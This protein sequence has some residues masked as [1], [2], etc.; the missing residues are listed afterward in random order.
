MKPQA[1]EEVTGAAL[2]DLLGYHL[3]RASIRDLAGF[4][5]ALGD[6]IKSIPFAVLCMIDEAPGITAA[7]IC[8][9]AG[10]QRANIAPM[11]AEFDARGLIE[12]RPDREDHRIQRL[13]LS[14]AGA[15]SLAEWRAR[16]A[17][18][19][20]RTFAALTAAERQTLLRLLARVWKQD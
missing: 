9:A 6:D 13:H 11:L 14:P 1:V 4:A 3:R 18:Q 7:D 12:R 2:E 16:A 20:A 17:A 10:L 19:E 8:R 5:S 15:G